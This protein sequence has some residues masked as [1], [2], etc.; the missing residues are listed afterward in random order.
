MSASSKT[1]LTN[2]FV[3]QDYSI[4]WMKSLVCGF[5]NESHPLAA[6]N[7]CSVDGI[8]SPDNVAAIP[9]HG[10]LIIGEDT[11]KHQNDMVW[12]RDQDGGKMT[13]VAT[14]PYGSE[15]TSPYWYPNIGGHSYITLVVQHPYGESDTE[16]VSDAESTGEAGWVGYMGPLPKVSKV[17]SGA[18]AVAASVVR[19]TMAAA[20][21]LLAY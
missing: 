1:I 11:G 12:V 17:Y 21:T 14:T 8:A 4:G 9:E 5:K 18:S 15:T 20:L 2:R 6:D 13:R 10:Q 16:K 7:A 3:A 19:S